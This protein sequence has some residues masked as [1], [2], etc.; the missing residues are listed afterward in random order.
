M[1][2]GARS[3]WNEAGEGL[4]GWRRWAVAG[5]PGAHRCLGGPGAQL[6]LP[7]T[8]TWSWWTGTLWWNGRGLGAGEG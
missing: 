8:L 2:Q 3:A 6:R 1:A 4:Q 7:A 5:P